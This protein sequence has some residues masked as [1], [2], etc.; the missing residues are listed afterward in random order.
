MSSV[1]IL[2]AAAPGHLTCD[3]VLTPEDQAGLLAKLRA[4]LAR[5]QSGAF[6]CAAHR[7][8]PGVGWGG[9]HLAAPAVP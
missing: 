3:I 9:R 8:C 1:S 4:A 6:G 5:A 2:A 7:R